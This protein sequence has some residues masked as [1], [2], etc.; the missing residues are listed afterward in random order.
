[1]RSKIP[2]RRMWV[3]DC[4]LWLM[5]RIV[6]IVD[7]DGVHGEWREHQ[8]GLR[9]WSVTE[10]QVV[11]HVGNDGASRTR[12]GLGLVLAQ[13]SGWARR[14][15]EPGADWPATPPAVL[16]LVH[17]PPGSHCPGSAAHCPLSPTSLM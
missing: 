4:R 13:V 14:S 15:V 10:T 6:R 8:E 17:R 11:G 2:C 5:V 3:L 1:M 7:G 12:V 16:H 9:S